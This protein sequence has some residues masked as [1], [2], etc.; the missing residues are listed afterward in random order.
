MPRY[1]I[2]IEYDGT[3]FAGCGPEQAFD[4][5][6]GTSWVT[7][8]GTVANQPT[9]TFHPKAIVVE[10]PQPVDISQFQV[11]PSE[12][13]GTGTSSATV[14]GGSWTSASGT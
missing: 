6:E 1:K 14:Q 10:L 7:D 13:C 3:D 9:N 2:L 12:T 4:Q 5:S 8:A 11:D